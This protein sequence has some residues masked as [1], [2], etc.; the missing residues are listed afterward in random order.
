MD[1]RRHE[2][3]LER[4][5]AYEQAGWTDK[6]VDTLVELSEI[7]EREQDVVVCSEV[8]T[9]LPRYVDDKR[10]SHALERLSQIMAG[11]WGPYTEDLRWE[12]YAAH[13]LHDCGLLTR[14]EFAA[15]L[16]CLRESSS[17]DTQSGASL[18]RAVVTMGHRDMMS[19]MT[20]L[21]QDSRAPLLP[22][23]CFDPQP[24]A[25]ELFPEELVKRGAMAFDFLGKSLMV[26]V[27]NP[28]NSDLQQEVCRHSG[29][30]CLFYLCMAGDFDEACNRLSSL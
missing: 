20:F 4:V 29:R 30:D 1:T 21:S 27:L 24:E 6:V 14:V 28:Y 23:N 16:E 10:A 2:A 22:L 5:A 18:L 3:L 26:A 11:T 15:A 17:D 12:V 7:L 13:R 25:F 8:M 9:R 19:V